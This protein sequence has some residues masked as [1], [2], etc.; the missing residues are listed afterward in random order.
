MANP[1]MSN[2]KPAELSGVEYTAPA[3]WQITSSFPLQFGA[4][5]GK[6]QGVM[7]LIGWQKQ[8]QPA[9]SQIAFGQLTL[10]ITKPKSGTF[11]SLTQKEVQDIVKSSAKG[12]DQIQ[13]KF[14]GVSTQSSEPV[15]LKI[16]EQQ[17]GKIVSSIEFKNA[18]PEAA[19]ANLVYYG[20]IGDQLVMLYYQGS[21]RSEGL[22]EKMIENFAQTIK[23]SGKQL[24]E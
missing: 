4:M 15:F 21:Q 2:G 12:F 14:M 20:I 13:F 6:T 8:N 18:P 17:W 7:F 22:A 5:K 16:G 10:Q 9:A 19:F 3:G 23:S 24:A 11:Q 1:K